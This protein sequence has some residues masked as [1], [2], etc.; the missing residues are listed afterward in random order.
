MNLPSVA[1]TLGKSPGCWAMADPV[2]TL[3]MIFDLMLA[4][5]PALAGV[6]YSGRRVFAV[7]TEALSS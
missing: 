2:G 5:D 4:V 3:P 7:V 6:G 1:G